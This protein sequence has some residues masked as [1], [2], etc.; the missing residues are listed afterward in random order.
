MPGIRLN[1]RAIAVFKGES[2]ARDLAHWCHC[3]PCKHEVPSLISGTEKRD[4]ERKK[5]STVDVTVG[6]F[7]ESSGLLTDV[8]PRKTFDPIGLFVTKLSLTSARV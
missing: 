5:D 7:R 2:T 6:F 8:R 3:L 1:P 4:T